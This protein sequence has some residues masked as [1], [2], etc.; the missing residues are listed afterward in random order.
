MK[1]IASLLAALFIALALDRASKLWA[2]LALDLYEP[3][4]VIGE[5]FRLTLG[6]NTGVAFGMFSNGGRW[7]LV[8]TGI[9]IVGLAIWFAT[10]LRQG[11]F[12]PL[13]GAAI[14]LLLGGAIGNFVDRLSDGRV[15]DFLDVGLGSLRWPTF[16]LADS[17]ILVG[18]ALLMLLEMRVISPRPDTPHLPPQDDEAETKQHNWTIDKMSD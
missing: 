17:F 8:I 12:P 6:Y 13:A 4:P 11:Q 18:L 3:V 14:G 16:N 2:E 10:T 1:V 7:P 15:T 5:L 9:V